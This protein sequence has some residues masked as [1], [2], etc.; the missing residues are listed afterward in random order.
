[1]TKIVNVYFQ[2]VTKV[3]MGSLTIDDDQD[4]ED[5]MKEW[6]GQ[7]FAKVHYMNNKIFIYIPWT[8]VV[9]CSYSDDKMR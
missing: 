1:M 8:N 7:G 6:Q 4:I 5:L 2:A 9:Y 3:S